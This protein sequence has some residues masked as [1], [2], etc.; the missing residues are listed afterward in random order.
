MPR[1][2]RT[3]PSGEGSMTG[4]KQGRCVGSNNPG[5]EN[6][7][8]FGRRNHSNGFGNN[9]NYQ[10][11]FRNRNSQDFYSEDLS[12]E[13]SDLKSQIMGLKDQISKLSK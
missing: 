3:G 9:R 1:G 2:D 4:R 10:G 8:G 5:F 13:V 12:N 6:G 7:G 11:G